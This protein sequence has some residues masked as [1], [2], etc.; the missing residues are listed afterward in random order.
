MA[1]LPPVANVARVVMKYLW[2]N[3]PCVNVFHARQAVGGAPPLVTDLS[4]IFLQWWNSDLKVTG[5]L[6]ADLQLV[7]IEVTDLTSAVGAQVKNVTG[8]PNAASGGGSVPNN[9]AA[10]MHWYT[11][12]RVSGGVATS[13]IPG[14]PESGTSGQQLSSSYRTQLET[15]LKNILTRLAAMS[16]PHELVQVSYY[17][18]HGIRETPQVRPI[19]SSQLA[20]QM[21]SQKCRLT[22]RR[23]HKK[24]PT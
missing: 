24:R 23:R 3:E 19:L 17:E 13:Y 1:V 21:G 15:P 10:I 22:G 5:N 11:G 8:L 16:T 14:V 12:Y 18:N 6:S 9:S 20:F 2:S 4:T 7:E